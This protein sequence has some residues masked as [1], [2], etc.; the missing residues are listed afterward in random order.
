MNF[1]EE[2]N[3]NKTNSLKYDFK[4]DKNKPD[5]V[6]PMW[7]ADMDFKCCE[8]ILNDMHKKI[9]HGV[10]GYS[11][12][13]ETYFNA[14]ENW[15]KQN[16]NVELKRE[17]LITTPGIVFALAT[18]VKTLT[19]ENDYVLINNPVYYPFTEVVEDNKRKIVSSDL[20]LTNGHYEI[21][22]EDF[23]NKIKQYNVKAYF[24]CSPHNPVGRVWT[25]D[26][27]NKIIE[28]CKRYNVFIV[29]DEVHSDFIWKG[30]HTC[31][32]NYTDIQNQ[33]ILCTAPTK[34]FNLAGLQVS[35]IFIPNEKV[36]EKFQLE[37]WNTGYSLINV[38]GLVACQS[39]YE[40]GQKW[41]NELKKYLLDN[42]NYVDTFLKEKLPKVKLIYPEGTYLLW[43][44]FSG[45]NLSDEKIEELMIKEAKLWL[46]NGK[47]FGNSGKGFQRINI[48]LPREK[49]KAA[50]EKLVKTFK[51]F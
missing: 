16:H 17:W 27:L 30:N 51:N 37:L 33:V 15:Y 26:E 39:A 9:D 44:D 10:F 6:F 14:I 22:F 41:L 20:V 25:K 4:S 42:V 21:D 45:L 12:N 48:A 23:E 5:D 36:R 49:L 19:E 29:C 31:I 47:M 28:I 24:L 18:A 32:L 34:T 7:V 3:R 46:D 2:I 11:K 43:L 35:N 1:D 40:K 13:D 8:E 50:L 38:M